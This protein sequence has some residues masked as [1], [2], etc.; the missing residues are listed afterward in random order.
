M[1]N[2]YFWNLTHI[3]WFVTDTEKSS[4]KGIDFIS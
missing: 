4:L 3:N 1:F 2:Q